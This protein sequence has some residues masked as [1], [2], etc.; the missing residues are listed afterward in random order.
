M[1]AIV[2]ML[3]AIGSDL[4]PLALEVAVVLRL[5]ALRREI[6]FEGEIKSPS[7]SLRLRVR[8]VIPATDAPREGRDRSG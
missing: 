1:R 7:L 5:M 6:E 3:L 2:S 8:P 4:F